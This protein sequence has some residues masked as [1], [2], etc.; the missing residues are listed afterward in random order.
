MKE[1][2]MKQVWA[3][4]AMLALLMDKTYDGTFE[5]IARDAWRMADCME[6]EEQERDEYRSLRVHLWSLR[7]Q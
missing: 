6:D 1:P 4:F 2:N 3:G 7:H 5:D